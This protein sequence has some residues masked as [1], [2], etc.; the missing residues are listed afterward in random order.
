M[1]HIAVPSVPLSVNH[2]YAKKRGGG[3]VLTKAGKKYKNE[4]KTY[5]ARHYPEE[6]KF[7]KPNSQYVVIVEFTF[8]GRDTLLCKGWGTGAKSRHKRLDVT[9][10]T[11]L[12]EDALA[13]AVAVDDKDNFFVGV[14]KTWHR[15][16]EA[17]HIWVWN[18]EEEPNN[19]ID[20]LVRQLKS[21][22]AAQPHGAV[23]A[24]P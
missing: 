24:V 23:P 16:Y 8:K 14:G 13:A 19:P 18:R 17:T 10:R 9:N 12:F 15:D 7:F 4:T 5:I 21:A 3:R 20:E 11:K 22:L 1:I 2:A 6:L